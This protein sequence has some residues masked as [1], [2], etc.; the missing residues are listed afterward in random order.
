MGYV[1]GARR[2]T[3]GKIEEEWGTLMFF[4][5]T[6]MRAREREAGGRRDFDGSEK[7]IIFGDKRGRRG[8]ELK[9]LTA[10]PN[11]NPSPSPLS[12]ARALSHPNPSPTLTRTPTLTP[13]PN[14]RP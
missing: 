10:G 5:S 3:L 13:D 9:C 7:L 2:A 14:P 6:Q 11:P 1:T 12:L 8:A 4:M